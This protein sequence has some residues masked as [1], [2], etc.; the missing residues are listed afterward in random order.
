MKG[1]IFTDVRKENFL[2]LT[3]YKSTVLLPIANRPIL[4]YA[5]S[6]MLSMGVKDITFVLGKQSEDVVEYVR[7]YLDVKPTFVECPYYN[8]RDFGKDD[9]KVVIIDPMR[10]NFVENERKFLS[11]ETFLAVETTENHTHSG[12]YII[13]A[14]LFSYIYPHPYCNTAEFISEVSSFRVKTEYVKSVGYHKRLLDLEDYFDAN[15]DLMNKRKYE[16]CRLSR[17]RNRRKGSNLIAENALV[18]GKISN[19]IIGEGAI[20]PSS[21]ILDKCI[22]LPGEY[23]DGKHSYNIIGR[24]FALNPLIDSVNLKN[25]E[26]T[27]NIF[28]LFAEIRL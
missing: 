13:R 20:I 10:I 8:A 2:P 28:N 27:T 21:A 15:Y 18:S 5:V 17:V 23:V 14:D 12:T 7:G 4:D 26:N 25:L 9:E 22:V 19:C 1:V 6:R 24:D 16:A 3:H 11:S